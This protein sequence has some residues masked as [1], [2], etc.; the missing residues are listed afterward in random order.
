MSL[1][2]NEL[3]LL[4]E[5]EW[6]EEEK[7]MVD[8]FIENIKYYRK[9]IPSGLK[10]DICEAIQMCNV[11]KI[12][13]D[14]YRE[15][16]KNNNINIEDLENCTSNEKVATEPTTTTTEPTTTT[17]EP[18]ATEPTTTEPTVESTTTIIDISVVSMSTFE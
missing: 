2:E 1:L 15:Y 17:T 8:S 14:R 9:L 6:N 13:L 16:F 10:K 5:K 7:K 11:L 18:T 12:E 4:Q 3:K